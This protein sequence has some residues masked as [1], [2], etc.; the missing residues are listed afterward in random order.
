M[1]RAQ[2]GRRGGYRGPGA[3]PRSAQAQTSNPASKTIERQRIK[4]EKERSIACPT[5]SLPKISTKKQARIAAIFDD[6]RPC[7]TS[8]SCVFLASVPFLCSPCA[9]DAAVARG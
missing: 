8:V 3:D 1:E 9:R 6:T 2:P 4:T 7:V 5:P